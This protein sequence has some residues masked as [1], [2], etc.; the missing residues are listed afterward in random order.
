MC[1]FQVPVRL[2]YVEYRLIRLFGREEWS[3]IFLG[4]Q[5][6]ARNLR[7][8]NEVCNVC[9]FG[10]YQRRHMGLAIIHSGFIVEVI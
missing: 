2:D 5:I 8:Q 9:A 1:L 6:V 3:E 4:K 7:E 10:D